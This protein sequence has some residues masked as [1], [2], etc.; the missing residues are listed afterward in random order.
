MMTDP[1]A[2]MLTR[3]RNAATAQHKSLSLPAS[4]LKVRILELLKENGYIQDFQLVETKPQPHVTVQLKYDTTGKE[5]VIAGIERVSRP[6]RRV[7]V[8]KAEVPKVL[9]G[10]GVNVMSTSKGILTDREARD[11][12]VGGEVMLKVW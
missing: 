2:D 7:Y 6:G 12:G 5:C 4:K 10:L 11:K 9:S 8:G 1:I 3:I